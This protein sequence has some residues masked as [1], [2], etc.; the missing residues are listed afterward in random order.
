[1][2]PVDRQQPSINDIDIEAI[3]IPLLLESVFQRYGYDFRDY[4]PASIKRRLWNSVRKEGLTTISGLQERVLH[5][6]ESMERLV[7]DMSINVTSF[8]RDPTFYSVFREKVV[9]LLRTYPFI[10][11]W[12]AGCSTGEEAYSI[13]ILLHEEG[14]YEKSK[15]YA[16]DI[17]DTVLR[18]AKSGIYPMKSMQEYTQ[19]YIQAGGKKAFSEYYLA[20]DHDAIFD[21]KLKK[22]VVFA[23]H[24]LVLDQSFNEFN[25]ILCRNVLI[26][27]N[28][29][30]QDRVHDLFYKSLCNF[31]ILVLGA[32]ESLRFTSREQDYEELDSR[33]RLYRK[34]R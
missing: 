31:G 6:P 32:K 26:Y 30:L 5:D 8:F 29:K 27:F 1:M 7:V 17:N 10:R 2:E 21:S 25:V 16:T 28:K 9:P 24:D 14:L 18:R 11:V 13:A 15:I 12:H 4:A 19:N 23:C 20:I 34:V 22:N 33:W 3:E